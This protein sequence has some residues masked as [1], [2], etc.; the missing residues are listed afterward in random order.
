MKTRAE[1]GVGEVGASLGEIGDGEALGHG[2]G[3]EA[4]DLGEDEPHPV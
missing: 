1:D 3:A 2:G 4:L